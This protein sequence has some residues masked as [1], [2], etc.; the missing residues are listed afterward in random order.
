LRGNDIESDPSESMTVW[1]RVELLF[2]PKGKSG[3]Y[4][5]TSAEIIHT[6]LRYKR[7]A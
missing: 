1:M 4:S 6:A 3:E 2:K 7:G 5:W